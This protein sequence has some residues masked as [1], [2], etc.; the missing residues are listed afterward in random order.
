M[1]LRKLR[2][3]I[4]DD[5]IHAKLKKQAAAKSHFMGRYIELL[6]LKAE[7]EELEKKKCKK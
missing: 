3:F 6:I 7:K 5:D 1:A 2:S 4:I